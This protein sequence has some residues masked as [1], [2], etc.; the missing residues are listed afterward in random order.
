MVLE[1]PGDILEGV[2]WILFLDPLTAGPKA[3][4]PH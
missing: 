1:A 3:C 4:G 2:D